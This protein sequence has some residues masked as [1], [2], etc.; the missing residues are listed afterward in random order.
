[1]K[2]NVGK[3][4]L[5]KKL[6]EDRNFRH[7]FNLLSALAFVPVGDVKMLFEKIIQEDSFHPDLLEYATAYFKPTWIEGLDGERALYKL[8]Q[9]NC[10]ERLGSFQFE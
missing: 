7:S 8:K 6:K 9:W 3:R 1:M 5:L 10:F 2:K 4:S